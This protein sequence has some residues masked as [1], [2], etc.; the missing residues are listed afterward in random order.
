MIRAVCVLAAMAAARSTAAPLPDTD[1]FFLGTRW[2]GTLTQK[3]TFGGGAVGPPTF[4]T[5][6]TVTARDGD[7]FEATLA[8]TAD[9]IRV[10][11][12]VKGTITPAPGGKGYRVQFRSV[13]AVGVVSNTTPVLGVPYTGVL[14]GRVVRGTWRVPPN[15]GSTNVEGEFDLELAK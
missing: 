12:H 11:Y 13:G 4:R 5:V 15:E 6:L 10:T 2:V 1:P 9:D 14:V 7:R 8:E 3:G